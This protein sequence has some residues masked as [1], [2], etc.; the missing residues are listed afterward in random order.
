MMILGHEVV[1]T[2]KVSAQK[3]PGGKPRATRRRIRLPEPLGRDE[4]PPGS[5]TLFVF[6]W[7]VVGAGVL[8]TSECD[9][10]NDVMC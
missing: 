10:V 2:S 7:L 4:C 9:L 1:G 5:A 8:V 6:S 3:A